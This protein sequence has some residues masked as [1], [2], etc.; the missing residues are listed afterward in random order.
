MNTVS[1]DRPLQD[2]DWEPHIPR[3][4][5]ILEIRR[6]TARENYF[7]VQLPK[8]L[9][10]RPGQFVMLSRLGIGEAPISISSGPG[11]DNFLEMVIRETGR[12]TRVL[13]RLKPG[14]QV[15]I[16]GPFG[17]GFDLETFRGQD[18]LCIVGG[19]GLV[20]LRSLILPLIAQPDHYGSITI[21]SGC[22][23]PADEL[24]RE[25]L[26]AWAASGSARPVSV[27]RLV[28]QTANLPWNGQVGLVTAPIATLPLDPQRTI[29]ALC[30]PPVM[31]KFVIM[32]LVARGLP[33]HRIYVD[34]E[35]RMK[36]GVGRCG[37]CQINRVCCCQ[38]GPVFRFDR[39][40]TLQEALQ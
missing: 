10:H 20:P 40:G 34:L 14:D 27:I 18:V 25:E 5:R 7:K 8:P 26:E 19:L 15:G 24:Y 29:V 17:S 3:M 13:H 37:H 21:I 2:H 32:E 28:D 12:L 30:G 33:L 22:R 9:G 6:M 39:I 1:P 36:C 38:E 35:R 16:R 23:T 31:Y 11:D 4:A